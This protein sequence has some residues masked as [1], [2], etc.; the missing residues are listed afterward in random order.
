MGISYKNGS[1]CSDPTAYYAVQHMEAEE[2][3]LHIRYPIG[4]MVL[5]IERFFPCTVV[6]AR[7]L[8]PLIRR[9]CEKAEKEKL[10]QFLIKQEMNYRSRIQAFQNREKKSEDESEKRDLQQRIRE[11][12]RMLR[13]IQRNIEIFMEEG[14]E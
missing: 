8:S 6:K 4:Q 3:R 9:Y 12:E 14:T 5:E 13:R 7:K 10:R 1:G 11:C 2:R